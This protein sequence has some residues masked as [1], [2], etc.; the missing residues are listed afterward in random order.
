MRQTVAVGAEVRLF[1]QC[2]EG[3]LAKV[4][5]RH[6]HCRTRGQLDPQLIRC[7]QLQ[8]PF[9]RHAGKM[10]SGVERLL[11][12][13]G[14]LGKRAGAG[15][16]GDRKHAGE[17]TH[18]HRVD[19]R[20][21]RVVGRESVVGLGAREFVLGQSCARQDSPAEPSAGLTADGV[22]R[23]RL[24]GV[25]QVDR[26]EVAFV[27]GPRVAERQREARPV[28]LGVLSELDPVLDL[29]GRQ[30]QA[31]H[32]LALPHGVVAIA[33]NLRKRAG[34]RLPQVLI[35]QVDVEEDQSGGHAVDVEMVNTGVDREMVSVLDNA[36]CEAIPLECLRRRRH[37]VYAYL[38]GAHISE[39]HRNEI[40]DFWAV[41]RAT[42]NV[43]VLE[44]EPVV[45]GIVTTDM[46][47]DRCR[48]CRNVTHTGN[49]PR[50]DHQAGQL[51]AHRLGVVSEPSVLSLLI[52]RS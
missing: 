38:F 15:R 43:V 4:E 9:K 32:L 46:R 8:D 50:H 1:P 49:V 30:G 17:P 26:Q 39:L 7:R 27:V 2:G 5:E 45:V 28:A 29:W 6:H 10:L 52:T 44:F 3:Y 47:I 21:P 31:R 13:P 37:R 41:D 16:H 25:Q 36:E 12:C 33:P 14:H 19:A 22:E 40:D 48:H 11:R 35:H 42:D 18:T 24:G 51:P 34:G 20:R 23:L